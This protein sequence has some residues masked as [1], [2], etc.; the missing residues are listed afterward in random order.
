M[1]L[2]SIS[3]LRSVLS[4]N[5]ETGIIS[6]R[7]SPA[8]RVKVG[9]EAGHLGSSGYRRIRIGGRHR[10]SVHRLAWALFHGKW[11]KLLD[12]ANGIKDDNR[13]ANLRLATYGQNRANSVAQ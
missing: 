12:H 3:Y 1:P 13:I 9:D 5:P 2:P 4:Y 11:P 8:R 7:V 6:W 10:I